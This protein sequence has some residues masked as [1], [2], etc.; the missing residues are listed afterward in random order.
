MLEGSFFV[1]ITRKIN[2]NVAMAQDADGNE[3]VVFGKG[4]GFRSTPYE[5]EDTS[6]IQ[7]VFHHV[8]EDLLQTINSISAEVVGV[9]LDIVKQAEEKLDC[10]LNPNLYLTL[11]DHLQ[12]SA[13][14]VAD[15]V[16]IENPLAGEIPYVY[17]DEYELGQ[18]GIRIMQEVTGI[19]LPDVEACS[20]ALHI[21]NAEGDG[22]NRSTSMREVMKSVEIIE[23]V[24]E[25]LEKR[26]KRT[27]DRSSHSYTRFVAHLRYLIK[28]LQ[29]GSAPASSSDITMLESVAKDFPRA[30][31]SAEAISWL[32]KLKY[33]WILSDE[34]KLYL[35]MYIV[36]L[37][38]EKDD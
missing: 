16:F 25:L 20:I 8:N 9:S 28:R 22:A 12:F 21:V 5:L 26:Y 38:P 37:N 23:E 15:G 6:S 29:S 35:M 34:E 7:R 17:A 13:E 4:I 32:F 19:R 33:H 10:K 11:A 18:E 30:H 14:R 1:L 2:N 24:T 36:R 27:I 3:L 31:G